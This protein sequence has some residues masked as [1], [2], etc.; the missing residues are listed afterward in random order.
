MIFSW[1]AFKI[2]WLPSISLISVTQKKPY[3]SK[4][5]FLNIKSYENK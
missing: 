3:Y 1:T 2:T 5:I 4:R